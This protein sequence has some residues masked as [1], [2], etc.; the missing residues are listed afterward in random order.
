MEMAHDIIVE[1]RFMISGLSPG[2]FEDGDDSSQSECY[3]QYKHS[4]SEV[5]NSTDLSCTLLVDGWVV[6]AMIV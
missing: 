6:V 3:H 4:V 5:P 2:C 1:S